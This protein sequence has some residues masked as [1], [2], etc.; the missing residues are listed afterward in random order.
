MIHLFDIAPDINAGDQDDIAPDKDYC[1]FLPGCEYS[2]A[3]QCVNWLKYKN[4][5]P[6]FVFGPN[7]DAVYKH[8]I[9]SW[10]LICKCALKRIEDDQDEPKDALLYT[11]SINR[12]VLAS[13]LE[14]RTMFLEHPDLFSADE[15]TIR[16]LTRVF[17]PVVRMRRG[18]VHEADERMTRYNRWAI[19]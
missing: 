14:S 10:R 8:N 7:K 16:K 18:E 6:W 3:S 12:N 17:L 4:S 9:E 15:A 5:R 1:R 13:I 11:F 2:T 19:V